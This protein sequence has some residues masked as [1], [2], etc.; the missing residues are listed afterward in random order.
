V[1]MPMPQ[2]STPSPDA[3]AEIMRVP[4]FPGDHSGAGV[5]PKKPTRIW[6]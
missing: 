3:A 5:V 1:T 4:A 2:R 6:I